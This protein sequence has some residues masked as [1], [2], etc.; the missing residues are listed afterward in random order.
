LATFRSAA[1]QPAN[2]VPPQ[3]P[4]A[5]ITPPARRHHRQ[6]LPQERFTQ[7]FGDANFSVYHPDL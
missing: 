4:R 7:L 3:K 5:P 1:A 6:R 2:Q